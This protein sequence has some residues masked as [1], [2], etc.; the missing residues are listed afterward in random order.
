MDT[1]IFPTNTF[2][3]EKSWQVYQHTREYLLRTGAGEEIRRLSSAL[4]LTFFV[5]PESTDEIRSSHTFPW[6]ESFHD[7]QISFNLAAFGLYKHAHGA[8]RS[9]LELGLLHVYWKMND[10]GHRAFNHWLSSRQTTPFA[11]KVWKRILI[12]PN[13]RAY[14]ESFDLDSQFKLVSAHGDFV[15][16]RGAKFSNALHF[17][18]SSLRIHGQ[19]FSEEAF[20]AWR[21]GFSAVVRFLAVCY[22]VRYPIGTVRFDWGRKFGIDIPAFGGLP[23]NWISLLEELVTPDVFRKISAIAE[24]DSHVAEIMSWVRSLPDIS[25]Q[26][27][28]DQLIKLHKT[29]IEDMG[30]EKWLEYVQS[31]KSGQDTSAYDSLVS[32]LG[33]W[34][35]KHGFDATPPAS[36]PHQTGPATGQPDGPA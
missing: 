23:D 25:E 28:D 11:S 12:H 7:L 2:T 22:L 30:L 6:R 21:V 33:P 17:P 8:L 29:F 5:I 10:D 20:E 9:A 14:Q 24:T 15:H 34:A 13:F 32:R 18:G 19:R 27:V 31:C 1:S 36:P 4:H 35:R 16:T 26:A 3:P